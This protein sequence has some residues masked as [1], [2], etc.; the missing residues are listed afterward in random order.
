MHSVQFLLS[1]VLLSQEENFIKPGSS[2]NFV[3][4]YYQQ[5]SLLKDILWFHLKLFG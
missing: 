4:V 5:V 2:L 3:M 1:H